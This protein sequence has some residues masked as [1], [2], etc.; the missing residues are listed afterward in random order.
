MA[1]QSKEDIAVHV[2][3]VIA[4]TK[5]RFPN[6]AQVLTFG[7][8]THTVDDVTNDLQTFVTNRTAVDS[9]RAATQVALD[10]DEAAA[11]ALLVLLGEYTQFLRT[12]FGTAADVLGDFDLT[13]PKA[14]A[15]RTAAE[16]AVSAAKAK[17]TRQARGTTS[18]KQKKSVK[19]NVTA[20]LVVTPVTSAPAPAPVTE[21]PPAAA[22][23]VPATA[24]KVG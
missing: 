2:T 15:P 12:T 7:G 8:G 21:A 4:G 18:A 1:T 19:G 6:G 22:S 24:P 11:P 17:A 13:P 10:A 23:P 9:A 16:K 3:K 20:T 5:K 14:R